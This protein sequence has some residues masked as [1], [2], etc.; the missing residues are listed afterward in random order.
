MTSPSWAAAIWADANQLH[1]YL[2]SVKGSEGHA[3]HLPN[4]PAGLA[5]ALAIINDRH[6]GSTIGTAG[7]PTNYQLEREG[8]AVL[9]AKPKK[10]TPSFTKSQQEAAKAVL[11][12]LG[13][14]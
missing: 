2:P 5:R 9:K 6:A 3:V 13:M 1:L 7:S 10:P 4:T 8:S 14:I 12:E 11:R